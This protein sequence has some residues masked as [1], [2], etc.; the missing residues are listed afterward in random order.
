MNNDFWNAHYSANEYAYGTEPNDFLKEQTFPS[1]G[2]ILCL[3]EGEGRN[4]V[5]LAKQGYDVTGVDFSVA[6]IEKINRLAAENKVYIHTICAD[7]ANYQLEE[8]AWDG[9]VLIFAH[10][11][12]SVRKAVHSQVYKALKPGGKLVLEAYRL[13]Q[14]EYQTGGPKSLDLLYSKELLTTDFNLFQQLSVEEKTRDVHEG[15]YHFGTAAVVQ[16]VGVK[17]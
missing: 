3:A 9:I 17:E 1:N 10:L 6:G 12:E 5:Y 4:S 14:L 7:L 11:P 13:A 8:N 16:V 2:K 15:K